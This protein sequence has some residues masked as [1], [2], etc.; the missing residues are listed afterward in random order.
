M[1]DETKAPDEQDN[2]SQQQVDKAPDG[3][4]KKKRY[5]NLVQKVDT[6]TKAL[7][8]AQDTLT[9]KGEELTSLQKQLDEFKGTHETTLAEREEKLSELEKQLGEKDQSLTKLQALEKKVSVIKELGR[10]DLLPVLDHIP[11]GDPEQV[12]SAVKAL[13]ELVDTQVKQREE[14]L[15]KGVVNTPDASSP[16]SS[17]PATHKAWLQK[18]EN[19]PLG[20]P[21]RAEAL[22]T[23]GEWGRSQENLN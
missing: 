13:A 19:L 1:A 12:E 7:A 21:E 4:V 5:T 17:A 15:M 20:T 11:G 14:Q 18:I 23:Y 16:A 9:G 2:S 6:L 3:F 22:K 8:E 10:S